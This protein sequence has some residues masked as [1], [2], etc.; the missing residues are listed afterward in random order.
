MYLVL[1][2]GWAAKIKCR[3][4]RDAHPCRA[5]QDLIY[6]G[7]FLPA[8]PDLGFIFLLTGIPVRRKIKQVDKS[9]EMVR[10]SEICVV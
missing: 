3:T 4:Q 1:E 10:W 6:D 7:I 8:W 2:I 5:R 9:G